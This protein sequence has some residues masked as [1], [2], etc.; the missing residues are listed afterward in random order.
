MAHEEICSFF[1]TDIYHL[2][3]SFCISQEDMVLWVLHAEIITI[4]F[5]NA[6]IHLF[7]AGFGMEIIWFAYKL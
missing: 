5:M 6:E 7:R 4:C 2:A 3:A 1:Q